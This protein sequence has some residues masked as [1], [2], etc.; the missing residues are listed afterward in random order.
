MPAIKRYSNRKLYNTETG[1][2]ITVEEIGGLICQEED[3]QVIDHASG[4]DL[5]AVTLAQVILEQEKKIGGQLPQVLFTGLIQARASACHNLRDALHAFRNPD[6]HVEEE[7]QRRIRLLVDDLLLS[8]EEGAHI[9]T[10]LTDQRFSSAGPESDS[11]KVKGLL[12][13]LKQMEKELDDLKLAAG[14][15]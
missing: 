14:N 13:Q 10:L 6:S 9:E 3:V 4:A 12:A 7:I 15:S 1:R 5:T 2:Y 11:E 8:P